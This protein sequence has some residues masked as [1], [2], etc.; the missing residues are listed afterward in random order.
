MTAR[1]SLNVRA[2]KFIAH[3]RIVAIGA[4]ASC[5]ECRL[6]QRSSVDS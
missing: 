4:A 2:L 6:Q 5:A 1:S 3:D